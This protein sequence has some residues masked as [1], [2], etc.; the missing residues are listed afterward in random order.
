MYAQEL[1]TLFFRAYPQAQQGAPETEHMA[2]LMLANQFAVGLK[3]A[4]KVKVA[5]LEGSFEKL[6][7]S[8]V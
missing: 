7:D 1:R 5:G 8:N 3:Q 6:L 2:R 4:I